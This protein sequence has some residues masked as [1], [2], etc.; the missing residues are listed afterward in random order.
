MV[1]T[2]KF[3]LQKVL[4]KGNRRDFTRWFY[5]PKLLGTAALMGL[6]SKLSALWN[7]HLYF[8]IHERKS[9]ATFL[10]LNFPPIYWSNFLMNNLFSPSFWEL[11]RSFFS[12]H[13]PKTLMEYSQVICADTKMIYVDICCFILDN[14]ISW[15]LF[16][17][18]ESCH[19]LLLFHS[20]SYNYKKSPRFV[21]ASNFSP[22]KTVIFWWFYGI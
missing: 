3:Y 17:S 2:V 22:C 19:A 1:G 6:L 15:K 14:F 20:S 10:L 11:L 5:V 8:C 18:W 21:E 12:I 13:H 16:L 7:L 4:S 9:L